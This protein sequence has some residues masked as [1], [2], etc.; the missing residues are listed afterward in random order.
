[1]GILELS[2]RAVEDFRGDVPL[3][4]AMMRA[5]WG[6]G[7]RPPY[8]YTPELMESWLCQPGLTAALAPAIYDD[9][10]LVAFALGCPRDVAIGARRRRLVIVAFLT[11]AAERKSAGYGMLVWAGLIRRAREAGFDGVVNYCEDGGPMRRMI[12]TASQMLQLPLSR[13]KTFDHLVRLIEPRQGGG[14]GADAMSAAGAAQRLLAAA[15]GLGAGADVRRIWTLEQASWQL[16]R[17]G[18]VSVVGESGAI[19]TGTVAT[20]ADAARSRCLTIDD[21]L[22]AGL[23]PARRPALVEDLLAQGAA[24]GARF[25]SAPMLEYADLDPLRRA[26]FVAAGHVFHAYL[27]LWDEPSAAGPCERFYLDLV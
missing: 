21:I 4:A 16:A 26:G 3:L 2:G 5:S 10:R 15:D 27:S 23:D 20:V 19:L 9:D 25:A 22:W 12:E 13:A 1:M 11:V 24:L 17:P 6:E 18:A 7:P 8:L 14:K